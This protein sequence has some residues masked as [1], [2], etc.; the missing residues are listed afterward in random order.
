MIQKRSSDEDFHSVDDVS[1]VSQKYA[2]SM[3]LMEADRQQD[4]G[5]DDVPSQDRKD[6]IQIGMIEMG[7]SI[8]NKSTKRMFLNSDGSIS[9]VTDRLHHSK[10][11]VVSRESF[12]VSG[13]VILSV[14]KKSREQKVGITIM[15]RKVFDS[16]SLVV[17][18]ISTDSLFV[19]SPLSVGDTILVVNDQDFRDNSSAHDVIRA[20]RTAM[21]E[22]TICVRKSSEGLQNF[23]E[24]ARKVLVDERKEPVKVKQQLRTGSEVNLRSSKELEFD[25]ISYDGSIGS[26][27]GSRSVSLRKSYPGEDLGIEL[28]ESRYGT[29]AVLVIAKIFPRPYSG[30]NR[31]QPGDVILSI[32]G[33]S[34]Q[35]QP[36][37]QLAEKELRDAR[38]EV[39]IE[40]QRLRVKIQSAPVVEKKSG[41]N[42]VKTVDSTTEE[43][44]PSDLSIDSVGDARS[45]DVSALGSYL[46]GI[47]RDVRSFSDED[48]LDVKDD[49]PRSVASSQSTPSQITMSVLRRPTVQF[50]TVSKSSPDQ[51]VGL[52]MKVVHGALRVTEVSPT[53]LLAGKPILPGDTVAAINGKSFIANPDAQEAAKIV[54]N[55]LTVINFEIKATEKYNKPRRR[56][57]FNKLCCAKRTNPK[58]SGKQTKQNT[59]DNLVRV[60]GCPKRIHPESKS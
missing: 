9:I 16:T 41:R 20:I 30:S 56:I 25:D 12:N 38:S 17:S 48:D 1:D 21:G 11:P 43:E 5:V 8:T 58:S 54:S 50:I 18:N 2:I 29:A 7:E 47:S 26:Y 49:E 3:R 45:V 13:D 19:G 57:K 55:A 14:K 10:N 51:E 23:L 39:R 24:T 28:V 40:Y 59:Q 33:M 53:G 22:L 44:S 32:N 34:F 52:A 4:A 37:A 27:H 31:L 15:E 6:R 60:I 42:K 36:D 46:G 35:E